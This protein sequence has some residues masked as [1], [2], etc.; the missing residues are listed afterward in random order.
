MTL[1]TT[2]LIFDGHND[3]LLRL[4]LGHTTVEQVRNGG[5]KHHIDL[6][7]A[8]E[9][10]F[11]GGMFAIFNPDPPGA[12]SSLDNMTDDMALSGL[13]DPDVALRST[14]GQAAL[15]RE[16]EQDGSVI[17]CRTA[18]DIE[19]ALEK[20]PMAAVLHLEG[21]D[22]IDPEFRA[23]NVLYALGL[24]S[25]GPVWSRKTRWAEGV[26]FRFP[27]TGDTGPGLT[28]DGKR[29]IR[30]C[31]RLGIAIDLS[32]L[33]EKGM[34]DI[35][36]ITDVPLIATHSN[37]HAICAHARNLTD[38]QL[39][40]IAES[41]GMVGVNF[42]AAFLRPDGKMRSD[43]GLDVMLRHLDYLIGKLG[44]N[45]VGFGSDFDGAMVSREIK[46][47]AGLPKLRQA[48][49]DAG[50]GAELMTKLCHGNWID[51]LRRTWK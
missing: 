2:P 32:H 8:I 40:M 17:I 31:N 37:A 20:P 18:N 14:V 7:R 6:P 3:L 10:G 26:P 24:R 45:G 30:E 51:V 13:L 49:L 4:L 23:L 50:Y 39:D 33:N 5:G 47:V 41:R 34:D 16:L 1:P 43:F 36:A 11:G 12:S 48:M 21:A 28:E 42:A 44:E 22:S 19:A 15:L 29:L 25:L 9:G 35:A 46:D 27:S 38:R